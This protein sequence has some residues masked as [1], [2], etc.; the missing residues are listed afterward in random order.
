MRVCIFEDGKYD[1][2]YPLTHF[3]PVWELKCGHTLLY[4][5]ILRKLGDSFAL[6]ARDSL[7][8]VLRERHPGTPINDRSALTGDGIGSGID[9]ADPTGCRADKGLHVQYRSVDRV[10]QGRRRGIRGV[11][12]RDGH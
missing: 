1:Q 9:Q 12:V 11:S 8:D 7:T 10:G 5:K 4:Q 2:L 6:F 3:R